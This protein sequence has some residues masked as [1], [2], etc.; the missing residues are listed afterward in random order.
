MRIIN[1]C[2]TGNIGYVFFVDTSF[3]NDI[4][5]AFFNN[6]FLKLRKF[7]SIPPILKT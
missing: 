5:N 7:V 1:C 3:E 2:F 6:P 4:C